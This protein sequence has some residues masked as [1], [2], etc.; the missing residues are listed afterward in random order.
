MK[1]AF[2]PQIR[3]MTTDLRKLIA[4]TVDPANGVL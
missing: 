4:N 2:F 1:E 3:Q